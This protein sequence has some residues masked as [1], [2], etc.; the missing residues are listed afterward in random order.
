MTTVRR[1]SG[2]EL[3]LQHYYTAIVTLGVTVC[4]FS[5]LRL[6]GRAEVPPTQTISL[7][8]EFSTNLSM[9]CFSDSTDNPSFNRRTHSAVWFHV[10]YSFQSV[11]G[12]RLSD[13]AG[14]SLPRWGLHLLGESQCAIVQLFATKQ[15]H[16]LPLEGW[17]RW[18]LLATAW[19]DLPPEMDM[20]C[21]PRC[22]INLHGGREKGSEL[23]VEVAGIQSC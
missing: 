23:C 11:L 8:N 7:I 9:V 1:N 14:C 12:L 17:R 21:S 16:E 5:M 10:W 18:L 6:W 13:E 19:S 3:Q 2:Y 20:A 4:M 15:L 22:L